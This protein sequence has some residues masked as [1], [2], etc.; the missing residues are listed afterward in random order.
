MV[1]DI[2]FDITII[3][4]TTYTTIHNIHN[5]LINIML[6]VIYAMFVGL[7][8]YEYSSSMCLGKC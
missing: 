8:H 6:R 2:L 3:G 7:R 4:F 5:T 1:V